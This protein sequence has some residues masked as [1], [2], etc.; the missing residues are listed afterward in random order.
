MNS[1]DLSRSFAFAFLQQQCVICKLWA[2]QF[3][4]V[5][6]R[7]R[8][9]AITTCYAIVR[10]AAA[11]H[12]CTHLNPGGVCVISVKDGNDESLCGSPILCVFCENSHLCLLWDC[13]RFFCLFLFFN[14]SP[15]TFFLYKFDSVVQ[16]FF[17]FCCHFFFVK[18]WTVWINSYTFIFSWILLYTVYW[19]NV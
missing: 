11:C 4:H 18:V 16:D 6:A 12:L 2:H 17:W 13:K 1:A 5:R 7:V 14:F 15:S 10:R 3:S 19:I 9:G 8:G